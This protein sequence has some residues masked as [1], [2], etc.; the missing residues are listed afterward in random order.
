[1]AMQSIS[2]AGEF[3]STYAADTTIF[4]S[5]NSRTTILPVRPISLDPW[6]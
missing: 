1:M 4:P 6:I 5:L 2:P 3:K